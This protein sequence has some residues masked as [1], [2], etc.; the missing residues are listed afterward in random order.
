[1]TSA[2]TIDEPAIEDGPP[3]ARTRVRRG[4]A[5]AKYDRATIHAIL[6]AAS[7]CHVG[8]AVD[9]VPHVIPTAHWR[10]GDRVYWH[11]S[12]ASAMIRQAGRGLPVCF[13]ASILDGLVV[14]RSGF[15]TSFNYRSVVA[16]GAAEPVDGRDAKLAA[17]EALMEKLIP[18]RWAELR[19]PSE[20][21]LKATTV[22]SMP[23]DEASAKV[24][25]GGP[26]D[27]PE[28][29][30]TPLWAGWVPVHRT[31]GAPVPLPEL[32]AGVTAPEYLN[33]IRVDTD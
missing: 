28:D 31:L 16:F 27:L 7:M 10:I 4:A 23:L 20:Q 21:E 30:D 6:D 32:P 15:R 11:G 3:S 24:R 26:N 14:A 2:D 8:Y 9:G 22:L 1:M 12:S 33:R 5:R 29:Q 25:N 17:L 18:G 19:L 13:T